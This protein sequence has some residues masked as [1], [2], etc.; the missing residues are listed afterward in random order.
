MIEF[1]FVLT[2]KC[3]HMYSG[4]EHTQTTILSRRMIGLLS[5]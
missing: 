1:I 5:R 4:N 3:S 2:N